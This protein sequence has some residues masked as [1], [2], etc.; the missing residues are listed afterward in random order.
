[1]RLLTFVY[2]P[3]F[4]GKNKLNKLHASSFDLHQGVTLTKL[5]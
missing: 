3:R 5:A 4:L 1:L 2:V